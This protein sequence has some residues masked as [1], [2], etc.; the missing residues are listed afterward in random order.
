M[1][2]KG[3]K[4]FK[5]IQPIIS[6]P[7]RLI[8]TF[9]VQSLLNFFYEADL[10][11]KMNKDEGFWTYQLE[12]TFLSMYL[13]GII[14]NDRAK[15]V[16][17]LQEYAVWTRKNF[18]KGRCDAFINYKKNAVM[19]EAKR[20]FDNIYIKDEHWNIDAWLEWDYVKIGKQLE[21]YH[22]VQKIY[23]KKEDYDSLQLMTLVFNLVKI[24]PAKH[25]EESKR[26]LESKIN[27][28][29]PRD[30][31][32]TFLYDKLIDKETG[33]NTGLEIYGTIKTVYE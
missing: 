14:R 22:E 10:Y 3:V 30:W 17:V 26:H 31:F 33:L 5:A 29:F 4:N 24:N 23:I 8:N 25:H 27:E 9:I 6:N 15:E 20:D 19:I 18:S 7:G 12:R 1:L 21:N 13:N 28:N 11:L 32:Y 16:T 2:L